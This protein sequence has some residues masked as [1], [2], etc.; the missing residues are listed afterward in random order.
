MDLVDRLVV[1]TLEEE[2]QSISCR[3]KEDAATDI[4]NIALMKHR[5]FLLS[6]IPTSV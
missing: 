2:N 6:E 3:A 4:S 1:R 5:S